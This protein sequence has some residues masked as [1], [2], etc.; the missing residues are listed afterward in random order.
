MFSECSK[1]TELDLSSFDMSSCM[2]MVHMFVN[3]TNLKTI[4]AGDWTNSMAKSDD[5]FFI[6]DALVGAV[7]FNWQYTDNSM[8]NPTTGYFTAK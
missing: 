1:L 8:A 7:P 5:M 6:C 2:D 3:C 4:Y